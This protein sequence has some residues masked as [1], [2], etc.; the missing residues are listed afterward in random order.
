LPDKGERVALERVNSLLNSKELNNH[1]VFCTVTAKKSTVY[2]T[3][4][5]EA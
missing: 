3:F 1:V 2:I 4:I 5:L